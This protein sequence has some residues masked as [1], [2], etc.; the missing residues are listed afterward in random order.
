MKEDV[1]KDT[2]LMIYM[3]W[4]VLHCGFELN[5]SGFYREKHTKNLLV[6]CCSLLPLPRT[7]A[8]WMHVLRKAHGGHVMVG[9]YK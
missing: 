8:D 1:M 7:Q 9:G 3:Y 4:S 6:V 5:L 2:L